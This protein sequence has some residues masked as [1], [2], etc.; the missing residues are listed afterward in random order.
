MK[1]TIVKYRKLPDDLIEIVT[2]KNIA[3]TETIKK[4]FGQTINEIYYEYY[5]NYKQIGPDTIVINATA[6]LQ[7][8]IK[9]GQILT[10]DTFQ[11]IIA[12]MKTAG[13]RLVELKEH[14]SKVYE[15]RI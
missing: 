6:S 10:K 9:P 13:K 4:I 2:L 15:V 5:P 1:E 11:D 3:S 8:E 14:Y 7:F 12:T